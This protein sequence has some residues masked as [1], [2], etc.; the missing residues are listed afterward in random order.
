MPVADVFQKPLYHRCGDHVGDALR[1]ITAVTLKGYPDYFAVLNYRSS[2]VSRVNLRANLDREMLIDR[3]MRVQQEI[4][5]GHDT[6]GHRHPLASNW[7]T[8]CRDSRFQRGNPA[9]L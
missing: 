9:K 2:A 1:D 3:R 6:G 7:I 4:Y 8:V 5:P